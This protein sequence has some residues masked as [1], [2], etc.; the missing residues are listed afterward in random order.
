MADKQA[1]TQR[2]GV[3]AA[4]VAL[5]ACCVAALNLLL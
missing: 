4:A 3:A 1:T 5:L 2:D